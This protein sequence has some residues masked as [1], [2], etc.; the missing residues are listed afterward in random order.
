MSAA[1]EDAPPPRISRIRLLA[2]ATLL[3]GLAFVQD[4][5][6][7]I[8][9]T[10]L[11]LVVDPGGFLA[12]AAH[13]WDSQGFF[14][15][16]QNQAYGYA[17]PMGPFFWLGDLVGLEGWVIQRL[18]LSV[19]LVVAFVGA[20]RVTRELGV[21]RDLA[22]LL[23]GFAFALSP[24][25]V[26]ILGGIS[27]EVWPSA[28]AP[29][30]LL[31]LVIGARRGSPRR[32]AALSALA[33]GMVGG[34][35]AAATAA[36]LPLGVIWLLTRSP[37]ARRRSMML[38]WPVFTFLATCW[39]LV[40]LFAMGAYSPPFLDFIESAAITTFPDTLASAL[41]GTSAWI[42]YVEPGWRAGNDLLR[43]FVMPLNAAILLLLGVVGVSLRSNPHRFFLAASLATGLLLVTFGY[44]GPVQG[45]WAADAQALLDGVL[46]PLRNVHKFDPVIRLPLAVGLAWTV[47]RA[48][49][50]RSGP[51]PAAEPG[52]PGWLNVF[53]WRAPAVVVTGLAVLA[54]GVGSL[55]V[56]QSRLA[57]ERPALGIPGYWQSAARWLDRNAD[58]GT[59][60]L[61]PGSGFGTYTWGSTG[62][63]PLQ[64]LAESRWAV[65]N[66]IPLAPPGTIRMLDAVEERFASGRGSSGLAPYL[67]RAG[68]T[69]LVVRNDLE[70]DSD[71]PDPVLVHQTLRESPGIRRVASFGP[72][73]GGGPILGDAER[74]VVV[75]GGW[76]TTY[77][78]VEIFAVGSGPA[79]GTSSASPPTVVGG[80]EDLLD[81]SDLGVLGREP[82]TL[83]VDTP[84][85]RALPGELVLTDGL[86]ARERSFGRIHDSASAVL[87]DDAPR[88]SQNPTRDYRLEDDGDRWSTTARLSG[89]RA[90]RA[91]SS[92]SDAGNAGGTQPGARPQA[93]MDRR[94]FTSWRSGAGKEGRAWWQV[95]L[96]EPAGPMTVT[97]TGG[98]LASEVQ[99]VR[100]ITEAGASSPVRLGP[101]VTEDVGVRGPTRWVRVQ[102]ASLTTGEQL[103]LAE[104]VVPGVLARRDLVTPRIP[105]AWGNPGL[106]V[107]RRLAGAAPRCVTVD[108]D[109][110]CNQR[111]SP[112][113]A[114]EPG[115]LRRVVTLPE[116]GEFR[117]QITV[118][119][120]P[121]RAA[122]V[123]QQ[124]RLAQAR[125]SSQA[126]PDVRT[127]G[128]AA[129]DGDS[130][131]TWTAAVDDTSPT[132]E[133]NWVGMQTIR[134]LRL[135]VNRSA[136]VR[137]PT[138]LRVS[139][140]TG[141]GRTRSR[142][143]QV[144][145]R[146]GATFPA[147]RTDRL[148]IT[149]LDAEDVADLGFD[150]VPRPAPVGI[151]E[152]T[153]QGS[154][155][156]PSFASEDP[157]TLPCGRG[158]TVVVN[159]EAQRTRVET[160]TAAIM[161]GDQARASLC[162][163]SAI[164][165][166]AG[167]NTIR[168]T[169]G[170]A[171]LADSLVLGSPRLAG[172]AAVDVRDDGPVDVSFSVEEEGRSLAGMLF[173]ANPGWQARQDG[174]GLR[175]QVVDGWR[176]GWWVED[177]RV[178][179]TFAPDRVYRAGLVAG[180]LLALVLLGLVVMGRRWTD[181]GPALEERRASVAIMEVVA[182]LVAGL[183]A[184]WTGAG[185]AVATLVAVWSLPGRARPLV[186]WLLGGCVFVAT[187]A[188]AVRPWGSSAGWAGDL[189]WPDYLVLVSL[190]GVLVLAGAGDRRLPRL[191]QRI[192]GRSTRR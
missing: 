21:R 41:R 34:V 159:G 32:A 103:D 131:T 142:Q 171:F 39:W 60:L 75:N 45:W 50:A 85:D 23:A 121:R 1:Q 157:V 56:L 100:V 163:R 137:T 113:P 191:R 63:E 145:D 42:P 26:S 170:R 132:L 184:G 79:T 4:P 180:G 117:A 126:F 14:G 187:L 165:L 92:A 20:A 158:P 104:V 148:S 70:R 151:T 155:V 54:V 133:L 179:A 150:S 30:V 147:V 93:A 94:P 115:A 11:D 101:G 67:R 110:R 183:L 160:S 47:Q 83:A 114:E 81:L 5:G 181:R 27:I 66:A 128:Y 86:Q 65:R 68:V 84:T 91:S 53:G 77:P 7:L 186:P 8:A 136:A 49:D 48:L 19:V 58:D 62:D 172:F 125:G 35:N 168:A 24:R 138:R 46:A 78:A 124:G 190:V 52:V 120:N 139:W 99:R 71:I 90:V 169:G 174:R 118:S 122:E 111:Q 135:G 69:H 130:A 22:C 178:T 36:V 167:E 166:R 146:G 141:S 106:I 87:T 116:A 119:A 96:E 44:T 123:V 192:A 105:A 149:V 109:V 55:P 73:V 28:L 112:T 2:A 154:D 80:P 127:S 140:P 6:Y 164:D 31:P 189:A 3:A 182:V 97:V 72:A 13:L 156:Y 108:G 38:W 152:L 185:V 10:K 89:V 74:R 40:P 76:Q 176:Q 188:Y 177:G 16:L 17:W 82:T 102:D 98:P 107:L 144:D 161:R 12:R 15:Q 33:V 18:W 29:W 162:G 175:A 37:G 61:A 9:D 59:A 129:V 51:V 64:A 43:L 88:R 173:S 134:G 25:V 95:D 57:P 153:L 143:V